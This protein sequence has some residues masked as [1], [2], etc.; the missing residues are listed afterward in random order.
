[1]SNAYIVD[2]VR[3]PR[4]L[5]KKSGGAYANNKPV[6]L[7]ATLFNALQARNDLAPAI[8]NDVLVGCSTQVGGQGANI[9]K[10][11][12]LYAGWPDSISGG[13]VSRFCC[14]GLDAINLSASKLMAGIE[15]VV[16][17]GGV[18]H[19]SSTPIFSDKGAWFSDRDVMDR[20]RFIHMG[21]AAD[22]LACQHGYSRDDLD[23]LSVESHKRAAKA[24]V[25]NRFA[26]SLVPVDKNYIDKDQIQLL[27]DDAVRSECNAESIKNLSPSFNNAI[28]QFKDKVKELYPEVEFEARH[29]AANSP[30]LVDG[31]SLVLLA[32]E[33]ACKQY[34]LKPRARLVS[35]SNGSDEP[36]KML[37]GHIRATEKLLASHKLK[38]EDID[39]WEVNESFASTV[40]LYQHTFDIDNSRL[41][42]NGSAIAMGHPLG[43]TGGN[44]VSILLDELERKGKQRGVV[45]ICGGAGIGV[46]SLIERV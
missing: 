21:L 38:P 15:N 13:T 10:I 16:V 41:N 22:L 25:E 30:A 4:A 8:V 36:L 7:L 9:A 43:A 45:S 33:S 23:K 14:S 11:A 29:S 39:L 27:C 2:A 35:F 40:L 6:D 31:A 44:L 28:D 12:S 26:N 34:G 37:T 3:L 42:V 19:L 24:S 18:E 32:S 1:M 46:A 5:V 20:T 17:A